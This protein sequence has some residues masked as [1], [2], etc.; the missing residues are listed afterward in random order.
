MINA[1]E[2]TITF[3]EFA[4]ADELLNNYAKLINM[5][6]YIIEEG[7]NFEKPNSQ[8]ES[9]DAKKDQPSKK[10]GLLNGLKS[11]LL[12]VW[13]IIINALKKLFRAI[14]QKFSKFSKLKDLFRK[15]EDCKKVGET[16]V[17]V[18]KQLSDG[19]VT[20][21]SALYTEWDKALEDQMQYMIRSNDQYNTDEQRAARSDMIQRDKMRDK[22]LDKRNNSP[23]KKT[24]STLTKIGKFDMTLGATVA[25][26]T[27]IIHAIA[28]AVGKGSMSGLLAGYG[29]AASFMII[30]LLLIMLGNYRAGELP[31]DEKL[32]QVGYDLVDR[33]ERVKTV[34]GYHEGLRNGEIT[35]VGKIAARVS[36]LKADPIKIL[37]LPFQDLQV[38]KQMAIWQKKVDKNS[39]AY[40]RGGSPEMLTKVQQRAL[41]DAIVLCTTLDKDKFQLLVKNVTDA[42]EKV[43]KEIMSSSFATSEKKSSQKLA[44]KLTTFSKNCLTFTSA[45]TDIYNISTDM[46]N[47][48]GM[49]VQKC[50]KLLKKYGK[51]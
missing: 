41:V 22:I 3:S 46:M 21:E 51:I 12:K 40:K 16:L 50:E 42:S 17:E 15:K 13:D 36:M 29:T 24:V 38:L 8:P 45:L 23:T 47:D 20:T 26:G 31:T 33:A 25:G 35:G 34:V 37:T 30:G 7:V 11:A 1:I 48:M 27:S 28:S 6:S 19:D 49:T 4:V 43:K 10:G 39:W 2:N 14:Q 18:S 44:D 9:Q 32:M 5:E